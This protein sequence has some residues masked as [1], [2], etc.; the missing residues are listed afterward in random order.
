MIPLW[1]KK[2]LNLTFLSSKQFFNC[3]CVCQIVFPKKSLF[4][5][6]SRT[7]LSFLMW[8][9]WIFSV[10][11]LND[12][13]PKKK[14]C[15]DNW[16]LSISFQKSDFSDFSKIRII[17]LSIPDLVYKFSFVITVSIM[18]EKWTFWS[19]KKSSSMYLKYL[20]EKKNTTKLIMSHSRLLFY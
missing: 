15:I 11:F 1:W 6:L 13:P 12:A 16:N 17:I 3:F 7:D 19:A 18:E 5:K 14:L 8:K 2:D 4:Y 20:R 10:S 9:A